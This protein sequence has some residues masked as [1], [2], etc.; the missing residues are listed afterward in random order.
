MATTILLCLA[1]TIYFFMVGAWILGLIF[2]SL[3]VIM[4]VNEFLEG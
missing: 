2:G 1:M 4:L 3:A